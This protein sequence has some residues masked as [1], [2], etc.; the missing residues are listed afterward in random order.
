MLVADGCLEVFLGPSGRE[1]KRRMKMSRILSTFILIALAFNMQG[2]MALAKSTC[3]ISVV[4]R[5]ARSVAMG[6]AGVAVADSNNI[7]VNPAVISSTKT[8][9]ITSMSTQLL[10]VV[11]YK[12]LSGNYKTSRG[13]LGLSYV[14]ASSPAG[15]Y[16]TD[17]DS[18]TSAL[19][20]SYGS[21]VIALSYGVNL[22]ESMRHTR[23]TGGLSLGANLKYYQQGFSGASLS[24]ASGSGLSMDLGALL[25]ARPDFSFGFNLQNIG[26]RSIVWESGTEEELLTVAKVGIARKVLDNRMLLVADIDYYMNN[27]E[28]RPVTLH[29]GAEWR[30]VELF[31]LRAGLDQDA[32][33]SS[34]V[35]NNVCVGAGINVKGFELDLAYRQDATL[36]DNSNFY[37]SLSYAPDLSSL[38]KAQVKLDEEVLVGNVIDPTNSQE[39]VSSLDINPEHSTY[40]FQS[41]GLTK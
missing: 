16:T 4:S 15:Y 24:A 22:A 23:N 12:F 21:S 26:A 3:D 8:W 14:G 9:D 5:G 20:I 27:D 29:A 28:S 32:V 17:A 40:Y 25:V 34:I 10:G 7:F 39:D 11:D 6:G 41:I 18:L 13:T 38:P 31:V 30:P 35:V 1:V 36:S 37:L 2:G 33:S 19:P